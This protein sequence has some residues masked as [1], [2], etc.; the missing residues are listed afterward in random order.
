[1]LFLSAS[2]LFVGTVAST[3]T[4]SADPSVLTLGFDSMPA[5]KAPSGFSAARTG[6]GAS[7][8]WVVREDETAPSGTMVLGQTSSDPTSNRFLVCVYDGFS[9]ADVDLSVRFRP[10][11]GEVDQAAGLVWRYQD[12]DNYYVVRANA[13]ENNVVLYKVED[14]KRSDLR[15]TGA[16][17]FTYG[18]DANVPTGS[19]GALRV[20]ARGLKFS[21][22]LNGEHLFDV[23]DDT[24]HGTGRVGLWTKADSVT[25]F[26]SFEIQ[27]L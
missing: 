27:G 24:F 5:G 12:P 22:W 26:D 21:V 15:P 13:L 3:R 1:V 25:D 16:W 14:G 19:W 9:A 11:S 18:K 4:F 7:G 20:V 2:I 8:T 10:L 23:E 17:P 6:R